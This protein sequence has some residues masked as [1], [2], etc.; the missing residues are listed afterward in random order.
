MIKNMYIPARFD[1]PQLFTVHR[2]ER[3]SALDKATMGEKITLQQRSLKVELQL[4][5]FATFP[6]FEKHVASKFE[7]E[8][9]VRF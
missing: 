2:L 9:G 6:L 8:P 7:L 4:S 5:S 1:A 3:G